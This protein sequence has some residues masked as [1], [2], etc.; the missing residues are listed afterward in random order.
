MRT[1]QSREIPI[2][3]DNRSRWEVRA[4]LSGRRYSFRVSYNSRQE[5]WMLSISDTAGNLILGGLRLIPS[6]KMLNK[7]RASCP[8]LPPGELVLIDTE[9]RPETAVVTRDNLS[10]RYALTYMEFVEV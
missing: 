7:Y 10:H 3:S 1:I 9:G 6:V 5:A 2:F 4:D 8:G